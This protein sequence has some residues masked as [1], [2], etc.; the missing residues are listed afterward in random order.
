MLICLRAMLVAGIVSLCAAGISYAQCD[1]PPYPDDYPFGQPGNIDHPSGYDGYPGGHPDNPNAPHG[2]P[3]GNGIGS[4]NGGCG[5]AGVNGGAGGQGGE[6]GPDGGCGGA[7]GAGGNN[8]GGT[9]GNGGAGGVGVD[10]GGAGGQGGSGDH[11]GR[12]GCG[13]NATGQGG[14]AG[15]GGNGGAAVNGTGG[16]GGCGGTAVGVGGCG[17]DGGDGGNAYTPTTSNPARPGM[18]GMRGPGGGQGDPDQCDPQIGNWGEI[19]R[20]MLGGINIDIMPSALAY[21]PI[22]DILQQLADGDPL[23][24]SLTYGWTDYPG[25]QIKLGAPVSH[26]FMDSNNT[27]TYICFLHPDSLNGD[28][29]RVTLEAR[30]IGAD[31]FLQINFGADEEFATTP[32]V[33]IPLEDGWMSYQFTIVRPVSGVA[34]GKHLDMFAYSGRDI[35]VRL[36]EAHDLGVKGDVNLDSA[37][38]ILDAAIVLN[39][40][41][42]NGDIS[43]EDGDTNLDGVVD[44]QDVANVLDAMNE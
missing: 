22:F 4:G 44:I 13:G 38:N 41:S 42:L 33:P 1:G 14:Q 15:N 32:S 11:G 43:V 9:G 30:V 40:Y 25:S 35:E 34:M 17:G 16:N 29:V 39:N 26:N 5:G 2:G 27:Q 8:P 23:L 36:F 28:T 3:G 18:P 19:V 20:R 37:V 10:C 7:G 12:G 31:P 6:S 24:D 21:T